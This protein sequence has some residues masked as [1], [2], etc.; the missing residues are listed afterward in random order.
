ME[1]RGRRSAGEHVRDLEQ[2]VAL[3]AT[4]PTTSAHFPS[5]LTAQDPSVAGC[6]HLA[7]PLWVLGFPEQALQR[8]N[9]ALRL[10]T[11]I[12]HPFSIVY[13]S[14]LKSMLHSFRG[15]AAAAH[16]YAENVLQLSREHGFSAW[17]L[18]NG[19]CVSGWS[20]IDRREPASGIDRLAQGIAAI[21]SA[22]TE[23]VLPYYLGLLA[24]AY[25]TGGQIAQAVEA[26]SKMTGR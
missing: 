26:R 25:A 3:H 19:L 4:R 23:L 7:F 6:A 14:C 8:S 5:S 2:A 16:E 24:T 10:A 1:E 9:E 12:S 15:E 22:G 21:R 13:A 18:G 17:W 20:M 11:E